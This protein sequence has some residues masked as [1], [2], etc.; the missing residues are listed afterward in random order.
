MKNKGRVELVSEIN[1]SGSAKKMVGTRPHIPMSSGGS[2]SFRFHLVRLHLNPIISYHPEPLSS[3]Q[4]GVLM[5]K[6]N[7]VR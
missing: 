1:K 5:S 2:D 3:L 7:E 6:P 4:T